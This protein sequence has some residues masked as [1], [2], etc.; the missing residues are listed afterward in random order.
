MFRILHLVND[1]K[2]IDRGISLFEEAFPNQNLFLIW[3][4][5]N[6]GKLNHI[7]TTKQTHFRIILP[8]ETWWK[9]GFI[10]WND[11]NFIVLH[12]L[13]SPQ[14]LY[15]ANIIPN[16]IKM[17]AIIYGA[18]F[19]NHKSFYKEDLYGKI[20]FGIKKSVIRKPENVLLRK[21]KRF[22]ML[23]TNKQYAAQNPTLK[24]KE[25][26]FKR[27]DLLATHILPDYKNIAERFNYKPE[28]VNFSYYTIEDFDKINMLNIEKI[29]VLIGNSATQSNNH[30]EVFEILKDKKDNFEILCPLNYGDTEYGD[31]I[32]N[33]GVKLFGNQFIALRDF[34]TLDE[35]TKI[36]SGCGFVIMNHYR[37]QAA[38]NIIASLW[39]GAKV[40]LS[41]R[42]PIYIHLKDIGCIIFTVEH[43]LVE[44]NAFTSLMRTQIEINK[45]T[46]KNY[47]SRNTIVN[48][49]KE[50]ISISL[51]DH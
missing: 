14:H 29:K 47:Y 42:S 1:E 31:L 51:N 49:L 40:F 34:V 24:S 5:D 20:T 23:K 22:Y 8:D 17:V 43:D 6:A 41:E 16:S 48:A 19:Y 28:W 45:N 4:N 30:L 18:D 39:M 7:I 33:Q 25:N 27:I 15:F 2:F 32:E 46:L 11:F 9:K 26:A 3:S 10:N 44:T 13:Y 37:Q 21:M 50:K 12:N 38:G 36:Q 35:F